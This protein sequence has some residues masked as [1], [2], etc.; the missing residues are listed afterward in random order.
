[1]NDG[2]IVERIQMADNIGMMQQLFG[3]MPGMGAP[4]G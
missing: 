1:M 2:R 4:P 3:G